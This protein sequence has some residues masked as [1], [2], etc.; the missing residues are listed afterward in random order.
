M[1]GGGFVSH[2]RPRNPPRPLSTE[3]GQPSIRRGVVA[4]R[5]AARNMARRAY[6]GVEIP[7]LGVGRKISTLGQRRAPTVRAAGAIER[8]GQE[9][10]SRSTPKTR[11]RWAISVCPPLHIPARYTGTPPRLALGCAGTC[12]IPSPCAAGSVARR[13]WGRPRLWRRALVCVLPDML[14]R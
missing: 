3:T 11:A 14:R 13:A 10:G 2:L 8:R 7:T 6:P 1:V 12:C 9:G 4:M 5:K